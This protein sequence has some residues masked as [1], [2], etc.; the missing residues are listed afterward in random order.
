MRKIIDNLKYEGGNVH[1]H[2]LYVYGSTPMILQGK[3]HFQA[4]G[5]ITM[6][7]VKIV[8][9]D[10]MVELAKP[11][12]FKILKDSAILF[13]S[14]PSLA[15]DI[16]AFTPVPPVPDMMD[17]AERQMRMMFEQ[18]AK[19]RG[20]VSDNEPTGAE[21]EFDDDL[22][23]DEDDFGIPL[24]TE[25]LVIEDNI[26]EYPDKGEDD[27][28]AKESRLLESSEMESVSTEESSG[29]DE[30]KQGDTAATDRDQ[31][32]DGVGH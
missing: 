1:P 12:E 23:D 16:P 6:N 29:K 9:Q 18:W 10:M 2:F 19:D 27:E 4:I 3:V 14:T 32:A 13:H 20:L 5:S 22:D 26:L 17:A 8:N 25:S 7:G 24:D 15:K 30:G 21:Q 28:E 11:T 31:V